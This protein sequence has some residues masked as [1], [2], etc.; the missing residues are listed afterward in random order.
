[1]ENEKQLKYFF[2]FFLRGAA[3]GRRGKVFSV[4]CSERKRSAREAGR[5]SASPLKRKAEMLKS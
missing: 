4:Q 1:V 3:G 5:A 2:G